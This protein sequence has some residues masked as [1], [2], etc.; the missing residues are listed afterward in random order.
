MLTYKVYLYKY[1]ENKIIFWV[2]WIVDGNDWKESFSSLKLR[3]C[4]FAS[5][6]LIVIVVGS[7][8]YRWIISHVRN[9]NFLCQQQDL[10]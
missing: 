2:L 9:Y 6:I 5:S 4:D 1:I 10:V 7:P 8:N 3:F